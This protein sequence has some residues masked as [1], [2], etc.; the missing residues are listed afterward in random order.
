MINRRLSS[1]VVQRKEVKSTNEKNV[2]NLENFKVPNERCQTIYETQE[3]LIDR[4]LRWENSLVYQLVNF[5]FLLS[6]QAL[7]IELSPRSD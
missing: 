1:S 6:Y 3:R 5:L 4:C 7:V 2:H